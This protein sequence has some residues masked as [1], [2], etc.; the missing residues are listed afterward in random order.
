MGTVMRLPRILGGRTVAPPHE[1][2]TGPPVVI[3]PQSIDALVDQV[4]VAMNN[5]VIRDA[6][7]G[8]AAIALEQ[9]QRTLLE[10]TA[11]ILMDVG[12]KLND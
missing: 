1:D 10:H 2:V 9:A 5:K 8:R 11:R 6:E 7:A 3:Q 12:I 4:R